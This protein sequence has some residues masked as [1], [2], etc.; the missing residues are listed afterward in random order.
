MAEM[1]TKK[2]VEFNINLNCKD[3]FGMTGFH[4]ACREGN[5]K[6]V[7]ILMQNSP[8]YNINLNCKDKHGS[9]CFI[10]ACMNQDKKVAE[11]LMYKAAE[12]NIDLNHKDKD[13][14]TGQHENSCRNSYRKSLK[15]TRGSY[16]FFFEASNAGLFQGWVLLMK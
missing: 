16:S 10:F 1:L 13:G 12:F 2:S 7:E 8:E 9:T 11:I 4:Y 6:I 15:E 3:K 5:L 14:N